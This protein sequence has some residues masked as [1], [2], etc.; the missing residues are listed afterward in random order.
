MLYK[1]QRRLTTTPNA[2]V[3]REAPGFLTNSIETLNEYIDPA[4]STASESARLGC[5]TRQ[6]VWLVN[7]HRPS[8]LLHTPRMELRK[9]D[10]QLCHEA[11][12]LARLW[13]DKRAR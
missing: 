1:V 10:R 3:A 11:R 13:H 8:Q 4:V 7:H 2:C 12:G 9:L 5:I 6:L